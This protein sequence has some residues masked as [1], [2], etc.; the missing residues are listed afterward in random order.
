MT[1]DLKHYITYISLSLILVIIGG[2]TLFQF[3][4]IIDGPSISLRNATSGKLV[5]SAIFPIEGGTENVREI[6]INGRASPIDESGHFYDITL[7]SPGYNVITIS[8]E[9]KFNRRVERKIELVYEKP[10]ATITAT[11]SKAQVATTNAR[12]NDL[13]N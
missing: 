8:G 6:Q 2:Y 4:H 9:D 5:H 12:Q 11:T 1:S 7:L 10:V 3:R 13:T